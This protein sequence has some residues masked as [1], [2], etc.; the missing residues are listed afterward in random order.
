VAFKTMLGII[1]ARAIGVL[2]VHVTCWGGPACVTAQLQPPPEP[3][4]L[5]NVKPLGSVSTTVIAPVVPPEPILAR[6]MT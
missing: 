5:A 6:V 1:E 4:I 2:K 3:V